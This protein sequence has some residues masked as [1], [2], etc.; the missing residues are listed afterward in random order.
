MICRFLYYTVYFNKKDRNV[1]TIAEVMNIRFYNIVWLMLYLFLFLPVTG[2]VYYL[3]NKWEIK[4]DLDYYDNVWGFVFGI[5]ICSLLFAFFV[6]S[7]IESCYILANPD[8]ETLKS[9][10]YKNAKSIIVCISD[11]VAYVLLLYP[12]IKFIKNNIDHKEIGELVKLNFVYVFV[13]F[14]VF[15]VIMVWNFSRI[16]IRVKT[17]VLV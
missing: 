9:I 4:D 10:K 6:Y 7:S 1:M 15:C 2:F 17:G 14:V 12:S 16:V 11:F 8:Y 5:L 13:S 3:L